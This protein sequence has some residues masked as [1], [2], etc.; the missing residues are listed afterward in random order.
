MILTP[1]NVDCHVTLPRGVVSMQLEGRYHALAKER[2]ILL[3][4][5]SLEPP[6]SQM[7]HERGIGALATPAACPLFLR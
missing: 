5:E 1:C 3:R 6:M 2:T 4:C 7:G